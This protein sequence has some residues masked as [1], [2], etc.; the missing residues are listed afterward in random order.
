MKKEDIDKIGKLIECQDEISLKKYIKSLTNKEM[1]SLD[2]M[3]YAIMQEIEADTDLMNYFKEVSKRQSAVKELIQYCIKIENIRFFIDN[4]E[5][6]QLS[7]SFIGK[8]ENRFNERYKHNRKLAEEEKDKRS[9]KIIIPG[10][11]LMSTMAIW[12]TIYFLKPYF[13]THITKEATIIEAEIVEQSSRTSWIVA[14]PTSS[15]YVKYKYILNGVEYIK[16]DSVEVVGYRYALDL[17]NESNVEIYYYIE[18]PNVSHLYINNW[19]MN[20]ITIVF[21]IITLMA[22]IKSY[23]LVRREDNRKS[24]D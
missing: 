7:N 12:F 9:R 18:E 6:Y 13:V 24:R 8:M 15:I 5:Q 23:S 1:N 3:G 20:F 2:E 21:D 22:I 11:I 4:R 10:L 17:N 16:E 14:P 19:Y